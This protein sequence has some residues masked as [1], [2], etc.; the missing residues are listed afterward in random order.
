MPQPD[1]RPIGMRSIY[2]RADG[3]YYAESSPGA[4]GEHHDDLPLDPAAVERK[5]HGDDPTVERIVGAAP[6]QGDA[7]DPGWKS[8]PLTTDMPGFGRPGP[9]AP[10]GMLVVGDA[11]LLGAYPPDAVQRAHAH[12]RAVRGTVLGVPMIADYRS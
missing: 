10:Y 8:V 1:D 9:G 4:G 7:A 6:G 11:G 12:A 2:Q 5:A 3:S